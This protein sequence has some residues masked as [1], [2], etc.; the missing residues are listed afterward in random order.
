[1]QRVRGLGCVHIQPSKGMWGFVVWVFFPF[2]STLRMPAKG[3]RMCVG[4]W[5]GWVSEVHVIPEPF[6]KG[7]QSTK[8][9]MKLTS[10]FWS[11]GV[12]SEPSFH[13]GNDRMGLNLMVGTG[14]AWHVQRFIV[15]GTWASNRSSVT[16]ERTSSALWAPKL[17]LVKGELRNPSPGL[18]HPN[19]LALLHLA[20]RRPVPLLSGRHKMPYK[21]LHQSFSGNPD[22]KGCRFQS[23]V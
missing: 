18:W 7:R 15:T 10:P 19:L 6:S 3:V 11:S 5:E 17:K 8:H 9:V 13:K 2:L 20:V 16:I 21:M 22:C 14:W 12:L 4:G 1:M 23:L